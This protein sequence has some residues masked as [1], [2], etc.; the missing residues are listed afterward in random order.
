MVNNLQ[1]ATVLDSLPDNIEAADPNDASLLAMAVVGNVDFL[2]TGDKR[3][4]LLQQ[5]HIGKTRIITP[6]TFC[7]DVL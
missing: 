7:H 3:A 2:V 4:G 1:R 5:G 6:S